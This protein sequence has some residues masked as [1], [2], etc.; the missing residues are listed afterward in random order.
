MALKPIPKGV[1]ISDSIT[2]HI[3]KRFISSIDLIGSG[4]VE[5]TIDRVEHLE[6]IK[7]ENG[8]TESNVNL[9]YFVETPKPL[10]LNI[11][12]IRSIVTILGT[13]LTKAWKGKKVKLS[14]KKVKA[15]GEMRDAIRII[16]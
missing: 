9:L 5:L 16:R 3:D 2:K 7:Y 11:T 8:T 14:V 15:F 1:E 13:N 10:A 12:N 4:D 6:T